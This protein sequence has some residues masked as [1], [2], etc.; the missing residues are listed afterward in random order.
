VQCLVF[1]ALSAE[2]LLHRFHAVFAPRLPSIEHSPRAASSSAAASGR[3]SP[4][5]LAAVCVFGWA[6]L[7][8]FALNTL[9][10]FQHFAFRRSGFV[11]SLL[12]CDFVAA[13]A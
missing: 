3:F 1:V 13:C 2:L 7:A 5:G 8:V 9:G 10:C 6:F 4:R 11:G 12:L